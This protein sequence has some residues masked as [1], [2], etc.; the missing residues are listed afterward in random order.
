M[1]IRARIAT[2]LARCAPLPAWAWGYLIKESA[3]TDLIATIRAVGRPSFHRRRQARRTISLPLRW[4]HRAHRR[5]RRCLGDPDGMGFRLGPSSRN[6][7][8]PRGTKVASA[9]D[10]NRFCGRC[11]VYLSQSACLP[12]SRGELSCLAGHSLHEPLETRV[13]CDCAWVSHVPRE[14]RATAPVHQ[15]LDL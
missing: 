2:S 9:A 14:S 7:R 5:S 15:P 3:E 1:V 10:F 6:V 8:H 11:P 12:R 4:A 13:E